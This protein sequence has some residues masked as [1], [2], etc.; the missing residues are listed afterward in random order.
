MK[1]VKAVDEVPIDFIPVYVRI[2]W[3]RRIIKQVAF[4]SSERKEFFTKSGDTF[5]RKYVQ[6]MKDSDYSNDKKRLTDVLLKI[7]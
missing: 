1:W 5:K 2:S 3:N 7:K 6:W 4:Y